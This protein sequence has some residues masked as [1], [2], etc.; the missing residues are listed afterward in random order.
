[1]SEAG[2]PGYAG[3]TVTIQER[4]DTINRAI[5]FIEETGEGFVHILRQTSIHPH[6]VDD[7]E[8]LVARLR[9]CL[10]SGHTFGAWKAAQQICR[11]AGLEY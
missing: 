4:V 8:E 5:K 7:R 11:A 2:Y 1:M 9:A 10:E 3:P 6:L